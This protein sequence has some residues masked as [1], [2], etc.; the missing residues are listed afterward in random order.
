MPQI[1]IEPLT[2][3]DAHAYWSVYVTG[4]TGLPT[5]SVAAHIERY[6]ALPAE[7]Q[8]TYFAVRQGD[9]IV[10]T[11]RLL[12]GMIT[13][14]AM[15]PAH[16]TDATAAIIQAVD[17]LRAQG[18]GGITA[19]I[20]DAYLGDFVALGFRRAF[21]RIRMEASTRPRPPSALPLKPPEEGEVPKLAHFFREVYEGH[22]EQSFGMHVGSEDDFRRLVTAILRGETGRF[23]PE[24]SFVALEGERLTGAVLLTHWMDV[25]LVAELGVVPDWRRRGVGRAL[26]SA[27]S[28]RLAALG[29][30][31]WALYVTVGNDA[32][33]SLYRAF[34][35]EQAGGETVTARLEGA[36]PGDSQG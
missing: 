21:S 13:G 22:M 34:G 7:E 9:A 14:F 24:A 33:I 31:R 1:R 28:T 35:F 16:R 29:D 26:L 36:T 3:V 12:P 2:T 15:D 4:R 25:P 20:E 11:M 19:S 6:L 32:A 5:P 18:S 17:L 23:M 8:R 30:A 27:A 10:G